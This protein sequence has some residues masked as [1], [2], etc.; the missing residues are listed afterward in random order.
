MANM[1]PVTISECSMRVRL[2]VSRPLPNL[3]NRVYIISMT[4]AILVAECSLLLEKDMITGKEA[5]N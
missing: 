5:D 3:P 2:S 4:A 1:I